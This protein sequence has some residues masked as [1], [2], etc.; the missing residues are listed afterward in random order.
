[1]ES[2]RSRHRKCLY[3]PPHSLPVAGMEPMGG[4]SG[5]TC[6]GRRGGR[7]ADATLTPGPTPP[8]PP[9]PPTLAPRERGLDRDP[10]PAAPDSGP[11][12]TRP[13]R[14]PRSPPRRPRPRPR[15]DAAPTPTAALAA[16]AV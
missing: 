7:T 8:T 10:G 9:T 14:R 16:V 4:L 12:R 5:G 15:P 13:R 1:M 2:R 6:A 11:A 3:C